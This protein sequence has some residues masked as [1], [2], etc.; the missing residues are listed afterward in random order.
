MVGWGG[1]GGGGWRCG[2]LLVGWGGGG[3]S[4]ANFLFLVSLSFSSMAWTFDSV[5]VSMVVC[6]LMVLGSLQRM[7][8]WPFRCLSHLCVGSP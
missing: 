4:A 5:F 1:G 7:T 2:C 6:S 3:T 8:A